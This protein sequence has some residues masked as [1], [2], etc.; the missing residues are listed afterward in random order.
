MLGGLCTGV[1]AVDWVMQNV[2]LVVP[3]NAEENSLLGRF[4]EG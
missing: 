4:I 1:A 3:Y 2:K